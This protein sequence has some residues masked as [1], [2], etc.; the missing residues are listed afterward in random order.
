MCIYYGLIVIYIC[1]P[2]YTGLHSIYVKLITFEQSVL[3]A[4]YFARSSLKAHY[5]SS[6]LWLAVKSV[7]CEVQLNTYWLL[8]DG[9]SINFWRDKWLSPPIIEV[10]NFPVLF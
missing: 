2:A 7:F 5:I 4:K 3:R 6:S 8:F 9:S 1:Q 10:A